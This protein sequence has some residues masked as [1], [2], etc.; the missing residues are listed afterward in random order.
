MKQQIKTFLAGGLLALA[1][2]GVAQAGPLEDGEAAHKRGDDAT[3][4][5]IWRPL[6][7]QGDARAQ[8]KLGW[9]YFY[10]GLDTF[11]RIINVPRDLGQA[12]A[13]LRKAA[14]QGN[15]PAQNTLGIAYELGLGVPQDYAQAVAWLRKAADLGVLSQFEIK[16]PR[17]ADRRE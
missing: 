2:L 14:D 5:Q 9:M 17:K 4:M 3:A 7:E 1:L 10:G 12:V 16:L 6:A 15:V 8:Y 13:W 11:G